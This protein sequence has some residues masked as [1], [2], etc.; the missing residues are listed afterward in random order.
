M[1]QSIYNFNSIKTIVEERGCKLNMTE[2]EFNLVYINVKS[3]ISIISSCTHATTVQFNN[4]LYSNTGHVCKNCHYERFQKKIPGDYNLQEYKVIKGLSKFCTDFDFK[5]CPDGC[6]ADF[7]IKPKI[8][9]EDS[10]LPIQMKTTMKS[11]YGIYKFR[12][13]SEYEDT[14]V[15]CFAIEDQRMWIVNYD[16]IKNTKMTIGI[17]SSIYD[18]YEIGTNEF[19]TTLQYLYDNSKKYELRDVL[20][21]LPEQMRQEHEFRD[22]REKM[23]QDLTFDYPEVDS[24]VY[25]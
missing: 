5:I 13:K 9:D 25:D 17:N 2:D 10:W 12:L 7:A 20:N 3:N 19:P 1:E 18:E 15:V 8:C 21:N 24:R 4:F 6:L 16:Q 11:S 23:F 22:F 14:C